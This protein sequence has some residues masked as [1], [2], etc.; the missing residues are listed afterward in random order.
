MTTT[1]RTIAATDFEY[2]EHF[3][4][5]L[6]PYGFDINLAD[7]SDVH[8][9]DAMDCPCGRYAYSRYDREAMYGGADEVDR[10]E[11]AIADFERQLAAM[12]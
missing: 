11:V 5:V 12:R 8:Y 10:E 7:D 9:C 6:A 1:A 2:I 4:T 3:R